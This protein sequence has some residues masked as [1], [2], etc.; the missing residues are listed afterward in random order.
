[1]INDIL[2][3]RDAVLL[4]KQTLIRRYFLLYIKWYKNP[5]K[6][7]CSVYVFIALYIKRFCLVVCTC[8]PL[9]NFKCLKMSRTVQIWIKEKFW[10]PI[11]WS[12]FGDCVDN[13]SILAFFL[14]A[15]LFSFFL[16]FFWVSMRW[17]LRQH[18]VLSLCRLPVC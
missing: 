6:Y 14:S 17:L 3:L 18:Y 8:N 15:R 5:E 4:A 10:V 9:D 7:I 16:F 11:I 12:N 1:M 13:F 2:K